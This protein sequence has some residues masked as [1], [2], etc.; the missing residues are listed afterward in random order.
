[1]RSSVL[2]LCSLLMFACADTESPKSLSQRVPSCESSPNSQIVDIAP[3]HSRP[4]WTTRGISTLSP[5]GNHTILIVFSEAP[6]ALT[7]TNLADADWPVHSWELQDTV[8]EL[9]VTTR[10]TGGFV[11]VSVAWHSGG[12][13]LRYESR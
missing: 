12:V 11:H 10:K 13:I 2:T 3:T 7:V 6:A 1:M 9:Y 5:V 4:T 8:L